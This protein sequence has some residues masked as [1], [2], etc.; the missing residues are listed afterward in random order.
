MAEQSASSGVPQFNKAEYSAQRANQCEMCGQA[1]GAA[2]YRVKNAVACEAC[3]LKAKSELPADAHSDFIRAL[4]YGIGAAILGMIVYAA[5]TIITS[6]EIG[7]MSLVVG[8]L[9]GRA[10]KIGAKG[11]GGTRYQIAAVI[12]TYAAV[13]MAAVPIAI[14]QESKHA[15]TQVTAPAASTPDS[16]AAS[17]AGS[18]SSAASGSS[19]RPSALGTLGVLIFLGLASPFLDLS[20]DFVH[21][22]IGLV[23]LFV[24]IRYAWRLTAGTET[25]PVSGPFA[26]RAPTASPATSA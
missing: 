24:G 14:F 11:A 21:G 1:L 17:S 4:V 18:E 5:F 9:V 16:P 25:P 7:I 15:D 6:I 12:L 2:Y 19:V 8:F 23:I 22:A 10:M 3:A 20:G 13:S 26:N